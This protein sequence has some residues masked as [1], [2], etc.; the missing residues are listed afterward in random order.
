MEGLVSTEE[1]ER[2]F[3]EEWEQAVA[4]EREKYGAYDPMK[5]RAWWGKQNKRRLIILAALAS[6]AFLGICPPWIGRGHY[7][8]YQAQS[9]LGHAPIF[10][11]PNA[12]DVE[13]EPGLDGREKM[14]IAELGTIEID[15]TR[16]F[17]EW[18]VVVFVALGAIVLAGLGDRPLDAN[19]GTAKSSERPGQQEK[20]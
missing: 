4:K 14:L 5:I 15:T 12:K 11:P 18:G 1:R 3:R 2:Q 7:K 6:M 17:I 10:A 20:E 19:S 13:E 16:L 8:E 9:S